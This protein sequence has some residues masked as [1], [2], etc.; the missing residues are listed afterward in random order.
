MS[1]DLVH[2]GGSRDNEDAAA[3]GELASGGREGS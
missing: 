2:E 3:E 1:Q